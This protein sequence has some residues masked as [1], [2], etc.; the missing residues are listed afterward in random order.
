MAG[1][2]AATSGS[3]VDVR[4]AAAHVGHRGRRAHLRARVHR[5][6]TDAAD[7]RLC[8]MC[9]H[10][11]AG[12]RRSGEP[13]GFR[14]AGHRRR[15]VGEGSVRAV[16]MRNPSSVGLSTAKIGG[17]LLP[18][19]AW[20]DT[21]AR[22]FAGDGRVR[23]RSAETRGATGRISCRVAGVRLPVAVPMGAAVIPWPSRVVARPVR[24]Q[25]EWHDGNVDDIDIV[26]QIDV[27]VAVE[28]FEILRRN[29]ATSP[30]ARAG[31][32]VPRQIIA[33]V[34]M[35]RS[36]CGAMRR[37]DAELANPAIINRSPIIEL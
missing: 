19:Y 20:H 12:D 25:H 3:G 2:A 32:G 8:D 28:V 4:G 23:L 21:D 35:R 17:T 14:P 24:V 11:G 10:R 29:P 37:V 5:R 13:T 22:P 16:H 34:E 7:V 26:G 30:N 15:H 18:G 9:R 33:L 6:P 36:W 1:R 31:T 27:V